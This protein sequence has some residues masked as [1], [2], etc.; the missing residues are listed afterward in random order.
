MGREQVLAQG[1]LSPRALC[2]ACV[3]V[4]LCTCVSM[5]VHVSTCVH[6]GV[7]EH[8]QVCSCDQD[9][10]CTS[11]RGTGP[12][13]LQQSTRA[14]HSGGADEAC[15]LDGRWD[16]SGLQKRRGKGTSGQ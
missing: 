15:V 1:G 13:R 3:H 9:F 4:R 5:C 14:F 7:C 11:R 16:G 2:T 8:V 6:V 10:S 12:P